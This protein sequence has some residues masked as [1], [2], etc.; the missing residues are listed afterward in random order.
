MHPGPVT[1]DG[2][3]GTGNAERI[4]L[5]PQE[6]VH[7]LVVLP[8]LGRRGSSTES[9]GQEEAQQEAAR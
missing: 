5:F 6:R 3:G 8:A 4:H 1:D 9:G 2:D 7:G